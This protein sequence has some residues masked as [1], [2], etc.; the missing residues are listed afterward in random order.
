MKTIFERASS[1]L[2]LGL[3]TYN[4]RNSFQKSDHHARRGRYDLWSIYAKIFSQNTTY[5]AAHEAFFESKF[6]HCKKV[7]FF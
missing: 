2:K 6:L 4:I 7:P 5:P 3:K 1:F